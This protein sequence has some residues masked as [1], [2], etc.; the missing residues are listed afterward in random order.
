MKVTTTRLLQDL[1]LLLAILLCTAPLFYAAPLQQKAPAK[2]VHAHE[3][4]L[5]LFG[6]I[7]QPQNPQRSVVLLKLTAKNIS[8]AKKIGDIIPTAN[9]YLIID[10]EKDYIDVRDMNNTMRIFK[11]GFNFNVPPSKTVVAPS[12]GIT[13]SYREDGFERDKGNIVMTEEYRR[14]LIDKDLP[15]ILMQASA[16]PVKD[17]NGNII[18][19]MIDQVEPNSIYEKAGIRNGDV[20]KAI[21]GEDLNNIQATI[22]LLHSLK[23]ADNIDMEVQRAGANIPMGIKIQK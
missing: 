17:P 7:V 6:A 15:A 3:V 19:F 1:C 20:I 21:N 23:N 2:Q 18:G 12:I 5:T 4:G 13:D 9:K 14:K 8:I 10:I 16:E 11:D 22:K